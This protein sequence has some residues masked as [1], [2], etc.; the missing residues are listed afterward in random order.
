MLVLALLLSLS[1]SLSLALFFCLARAHVLTI[2][3]RSRLRSNAAAG[4]RSFARALSFSLFLYLL[5]SLAPS[6]SLSLSLSLFLSLS[7][8]PDGSAAEHGVKGFWE[9]G[10][11][12]C[13]SFW[14]PIFNLCRYASVSWLSMLQVRRTDRWCWPAWIVVCH[15]DA[16][17]ISSVDVLFLV[18]LTFYVIGRLYGS[19]VLKSVN[20]S[21]SFW[22]PVYIQSRHP[23]LIFLT[24]YV[25]GGPYGSAVL[26]GV[27]A[28]SDKV[29]ESIRYVCTYAYV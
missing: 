7:R 4:V 6:L 25:I 5:F 18:L 21:L 23:F 2:N 26:K 20:I 10:G 8:S 17:C 28:D 16:L 12:F 3:V 13:L 14:R 9:G 15:S 22:R 1:L 19:A 24:P 29:W 27:Q 11:W